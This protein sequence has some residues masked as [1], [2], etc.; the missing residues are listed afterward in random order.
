M[1]EGKGDG[2]LG[3]CSEKQKAFQ[4]KGRKRA[5][6]YSVRSLVPYIVVAALLLFLTLT[7]FYLRHE[8]VDASATSATS[9]VQGFEGYSVVQ[10][11]DLLHV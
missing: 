9:A 3:S 7:S 5:S 10:V 2:L 1:S 11:M 8:N 6:R 4:A